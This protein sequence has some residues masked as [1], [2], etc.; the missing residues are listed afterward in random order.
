MPNAHN[1]LFRNARRSD[2]AGHLRAAVPRRR[3]DGRGP[4]GPGRSLATGR[5]KA[6]IGAEA[7]RAWCA[8]R[9]EGRPERIIA[10]SSAAPGAVDRLDQPNDR[11][12]AK[13]VRPT[14]RSAEKDGSM[15]TTRE[16]KRC[17]SLSNGRS[18]IRR[19][20]SGVRL[21]QTTPDRGVADE[22]RLQACH[23]PPFQSARPTGA[24]VDCQVLA[25]EPN[26]ALSYTW[27]AYG[28][29]SVV[30]WT[31][32]ATGTGTHL[33]MEQS[34]FPVGS[35]NRPSHGAQARVAAVLCKSGA[36]ASAE[37][38]RRSRMRCI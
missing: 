15:N 13:P 37:R 3:A 9:H 16:P 32:T 18:P 1:V 19:K 11:L 33:R 34:G 26:K 21:T 12:L 28:L 17:P 8:T 23:G 38:L 6:S 2:P 24:R 27:A 22:E 5:L 25:V 4:D 30:T 20:R 29:E 14:R 35:K 31:L 36:G 7:G 10:R